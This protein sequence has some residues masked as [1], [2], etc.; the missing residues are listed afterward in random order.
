MDSGNFFN[1][2]N[3]IIAEALLEYEIK[4][5]F[6]YNLLNYY[7]NYENYDLITTFKQF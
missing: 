7:D 1:D 3:V 5:N 2:P 4:F 6:L